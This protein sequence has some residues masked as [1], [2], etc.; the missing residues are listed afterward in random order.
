MLHM[1]RQVKCEWPIIDAAVSSSYLSCQRKSLNTQT[2]DGEARATERYVGNRRN[3]EI[4]GIRQGRMRRSGVCF[5]LRVR[6][7][8]V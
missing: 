4:C 2:F 3:C 7:G 6:N 5:R 8:E 1:R